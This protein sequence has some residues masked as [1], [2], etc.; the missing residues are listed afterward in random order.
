MIS[1]FVSVRPSELTG[2]SSV[3]HKAPFTKPY[4]SPSCQPDGDTRCREG[5]REGGREK[6][7][8]EK[9][10]EAYKREKDRDE[11]RQKM[12]VKDQEY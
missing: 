10:C 2:S 6:G 12:E 4:G 8:K 3:S 1:S 5:R 11:G 9:G 7:E